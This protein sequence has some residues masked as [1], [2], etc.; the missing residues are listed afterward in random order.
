MVAKGVLVIGL[1]VL[2]VASVLALGSSQ[3]HYFIDYASKSMVVHSPVHNG[4][5]LTATIQQIYLVEGQPLTVVAEVNNTSST[6]LTVNATSMDNPAYGPCQQG[7]ATGV[8]IYMGHYSAGNL[9][10]ANELLLYNPSLISCPAVFTFRYTFG[11]NSA[12]ATVQP[13]LGGYQPRSEAR[14][15]NETSVVGGYWVGSG[16]NYVFHAFPTGQYTVLVFDAWGDEALGYFQ[17]VS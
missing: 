7:F 13:S 2:A 14:L 10:Q 9:T 5:E 8:Q 15:V 1:C 16:Q 3:Q 6:P 4:L 17:V 12:L 11:A